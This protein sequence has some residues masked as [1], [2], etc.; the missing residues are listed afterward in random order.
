MNVS[1]MFQN[2]SE[3]QEIQE[4]EEI[5]MNILKLKC[6]SPNLSPNLSKYVQI[7]LGPPSPPAA[8]AVRPLAWSLAAPVP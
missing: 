5:A 6:L 3:I 4:I 2:V 8:S 1:K 7:I